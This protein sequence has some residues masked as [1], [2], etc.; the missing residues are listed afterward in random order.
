M[1]VPL[2]VWLAVLGLVGVMLAINLF[3]HRSAH[4]IG[5]REVGADARH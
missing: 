2:W 3:A 5:V 1:N 4:V